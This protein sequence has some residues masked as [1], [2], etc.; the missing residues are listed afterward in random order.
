MEIKLLFSTITWINRKTISWNHSCTLNCN[1]MR[2]LKSFTLSMSKPSNYK[3]ETNSTIKTKWRTI[4]KISVRL[5][6]NIPSKRHIFKA[7]N[8]YMFNYIL[9]SN[10]IDS[11]HN[12]CNKLCMKMKMCCCI[13]KIF[14]IATLL[15]MTYQ[16]EQGIAWNQ[17]YHFMYVVETWN[18]IQCFV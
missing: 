12:L 3:K 18:C 16:P 5:K 9:V 7:C 4:P 8:I 10:W 6:S 17:M 15:A 1:T 2:L 14:V 13:V 11:I